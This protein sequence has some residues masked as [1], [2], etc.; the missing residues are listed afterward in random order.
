MMQEAKQAPS[1]A[2]EGVLTI[3]ARNVAGLDSEKWRLWTAHNFF[4][5][6]A[7]NSSLTDY[8]IAS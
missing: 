8:I 1:V 2:L 3:L 6:T 5:S 7:V 4:N